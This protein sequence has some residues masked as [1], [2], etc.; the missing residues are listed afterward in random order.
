MHT[1]Q[2]HLYNPI[3]SLAVDPEGVLL[4]SG[5]SVNIYSHNIHIHNCII[6]EILVSLFLAT[7]DFIQNMLEIIEIILWHNSMVLEESDS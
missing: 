5:M 4:A 1:L 3:T 2:G 6:L 7:L